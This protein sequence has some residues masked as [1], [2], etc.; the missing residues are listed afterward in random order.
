M[1]MGTYFLGAIDYGP[2]AWPF[3]LSPIAPDVSETSSSAGGMTL[4]PFHAKCA[5]TRYPLKLL[6][7]GGPSGPG[8]GPGQWRQRP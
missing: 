4:I 7:S 6:G 1:T 2:V 3:E 8:P 5:T